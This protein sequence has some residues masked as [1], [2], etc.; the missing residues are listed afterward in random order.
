MESGFHID[1]PAL[2]G[3]FHALGKGLGNAAEIFTEYKGSDL[4]AFFARQRFD[5][6]MISCAV[7]ESKIFT[8]S[9]LHAI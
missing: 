1:K 3:G 5:S 4:R 6:S 8:K 9:P 7:I 2:G